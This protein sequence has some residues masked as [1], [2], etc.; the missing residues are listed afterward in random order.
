MG[1]LE[2]F[3][4]Q[5]QKLGRFFFGLDFVFAFFSFSLEE[6]SLD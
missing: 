1:G 3:L 4:G 6:Q 5:M 2:F